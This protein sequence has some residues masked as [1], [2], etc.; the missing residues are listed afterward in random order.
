MNFD[1]CS[2]R[3]NE[4]GV[5]HETASKSGVR[6]ASQRLGGRPMHFFMSKCRALYTIERPLNRKY[7]LIEVR[8]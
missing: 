2:A 4:E 3:R 8:K 7:K 1:G 6:C 5:S